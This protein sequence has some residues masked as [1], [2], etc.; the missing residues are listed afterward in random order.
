MTTQLDP[1]RDGG[2]VFDKEPRR[3]EVALECA[4]QPGTTYD[5]AGRLGYK[6]GSISQMVRTLEGYGVVIGARPAGANGTHYRLNPEWSAALKDAERRAL[7]GRLLPDSDLVIVDAEH[8]GVVWHLLEHPKVRADIAWL[9]ELRDSRRG[10]LLSIEPG[11][12]G[13]TRGILEALRGRG[14]QAERL[15]LGTTTPHHHLESL[16]HAARHR[17]A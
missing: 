16:A 11:D 6:E 15:T 14:A 12:P 1:D 9:T 17:H 10:A 13:A 7:T 3:R 2:R 4:R 5:L 8:V